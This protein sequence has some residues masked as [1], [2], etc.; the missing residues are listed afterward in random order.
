MSQLPASTVRT[1]RPQAVKPPAQR[2]SS[3]LAPEPIPGPVPVPAPVPAPAAPKNTV[4]LDVI[5]PRKLI[6]PT[7]PDG[8]RRSRRFQRDDEPALILRSP[9]PRT[10]SVQDSS[11]AESFYLQK[12]MQSQTPMIIVLDDNEKI[13]GCIEW[14]DRNVIK[15]RST[16]A[17]PFRANGRNGSGSRI[18]VYKASIKYLYKAGENAPI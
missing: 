8:A 6:R 11:H 5:G 4:D 18:L 9:A 16:S 3:A 12:Q 15:V 1:L 13:E 7:L 17:S 14:Y 10:A 2:G